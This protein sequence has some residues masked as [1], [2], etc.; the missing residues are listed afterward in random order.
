MIPID[1][2]SK[3]TWG[4]TSTLSVM[5]I[6]PDGIDSVTIDLSPIGG[7]YAQP[8]TKT[9]SNTW[10]VK[11]SAP[12]GTPVGTYQFLVTAKDK[13]YNPEYEKMDMSLADVNGDGIISEDDS[14]YLINYLIN[15]PG[16]ERLH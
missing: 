2:D 11:V 12:S 1:T 10:S 13:F 8:M 15:N 5:V 14:I 3:F 9:G 7:S 16:F 4:E 6:D